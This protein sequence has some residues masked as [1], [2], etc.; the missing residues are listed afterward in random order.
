MSFKEKA[1]VYKS[2][3]YPGKPLIK[4]ED[5]L[6]IKEYIIDMAPEKL[7]AQRQPFDNNEIYQFS[8]KEISLDSVKGAYITY[9]NYDDKDNRIIYGDL[10]GNLASYD[11]SKKT[12]THIGFFGSAITDYTNK[13]NVSFV[14][15][16]GNLNPSEQISGSI[17][18]IKNDTVNRIPQNFH[19]PV[20]TLVHD[21]NKDGHDELV[22]SE[23]GNLTGQI[24]L[25]VSKGGM[26]YEKRTLLNK[27]GTI[28]VLAKDMDKDGLDDLVALS[29]Q[30]DESIYIFYQV[31]DLRFKMERVF[32]F[33]P[34][35]GSSWFEIEM[36]T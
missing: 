3:M 4:R 24:S 23:F 19:R 27:P 6:A 13:D 21:L 29:A 20:N 12:T 33:S 17:L 18:V 34:I 16:A 32:R 30:G 35:Y 31:E 14:T 28:R 26:N 5:W 1:A 25:L 7:P 9:L 8:A 11:L 2:G 36:M 10:F 22:V 15:T